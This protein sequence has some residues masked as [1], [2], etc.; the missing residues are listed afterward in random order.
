VPIPAP[1][2]ASA[3]GW[4]HSRMPRRLISTGVDYAA[5]T[6]SDDMAGEVA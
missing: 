2:L 4:E 1:R 6:I 5:I 3:T